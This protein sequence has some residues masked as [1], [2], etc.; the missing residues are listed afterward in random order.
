MRLK[1]DIE[2]ERLKP[3]VVMDLVPLCS[4]QY[5]RL[6]GTTRIPGVE[7]GEAHPHT[8]RTFTPSP[9]LQPSHTFTPLTP[10]HTITQP[11]YSHPL[12]PSHNHT[13]HTTN[14]LLLYMYLYHLITHIISTLTP[15][16]PCSCTYCHT[17][18]PHMHPHTLTPSQTNWSRW[19]PMSVSTVQ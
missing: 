8:P 15:I 7:T 11:H 4:A 3:L 2:K 16:S 6:F 5:E 18:H 17:S 9:G 14:S 12:T 10:S 1:K 13:T 19:L